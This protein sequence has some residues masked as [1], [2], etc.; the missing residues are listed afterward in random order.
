MNKEIAETYEEYLAGAEQVAGFGRLGCYQGLQ[1]LEKYIREDENYT[2]K[3]EDSFVFIEGHIK[4]IEKENT[5]LKQALNEIREFSKLN[6]KIAKDNKQ[7]YI[8][9]YVLN[10][11]PQIIDK[12]LGDDK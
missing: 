5:I 2:E 3:L 7:D 8:P 10:G 9:R 4:R 6:M 11:I 12:V 1:Y